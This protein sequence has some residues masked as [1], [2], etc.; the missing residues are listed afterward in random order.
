MPPRRRPLVRSS[1]ASRRPPPARAA[2]RP[3][4]P[5]TL[6][7]GFD[8]LRLTGIQAYGHLGVTSKERDLGQRVEADVEIAYVPAVQR[9]PDSIDAYVDYEAVGQ[10][11]RS[12]IEL[13]RCK[14][15]ET[16]AEEVALALLEETGAPRIRVRLRKLHVPVSGFSGTP[17]VEIERGES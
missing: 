14:L 12:Q 7:G 2:R 15:I 16:L 3:S 13:S 5:R 10:L 4:L 11:V 17:E 1:R 6:R 8:W 9:R